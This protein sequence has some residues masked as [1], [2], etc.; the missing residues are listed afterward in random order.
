MTLDS[1][2]QVVTRSLVPDALPE[3]SASL[4][5]TFQSSG[6]LTVSLSS[7]NRETHLGR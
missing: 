2:I 3:P 6:R 7:S 5:P 1:F 4:L